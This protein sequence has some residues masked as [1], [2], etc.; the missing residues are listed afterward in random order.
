MAWD[1]ICKPKDVGGL[2]IRRLYDMNR[3]LIAKLGWLLL[4]NP[5][6]LWS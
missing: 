5:N 6:S 2:G 4:K 3:A 1:A